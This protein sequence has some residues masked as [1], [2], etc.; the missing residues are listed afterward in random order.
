MKKPQG[1]LHLLTSKV[2]NSIWVGMEH[3][4]NT[5]GLSKADQVRMAMVAYLGITDLRQ[6]FNPD[7]LKNREVNCN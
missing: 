2:P 3:I 4:T 7:E 1:M 6:P 5:S